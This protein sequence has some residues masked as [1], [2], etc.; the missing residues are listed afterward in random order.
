MIHFL[1]KRHVN[2]NII[3]L[4]IL[5]FFMTIVTGIFNQIKPIELLVFFCFQALC[6]VLPGAAIMALIP[7]K[8]LRRIEKVMLIYASGY[9][10]TILLYA[11]LMLTVGI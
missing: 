10:L 7:V 11:V 2:R 4:L 9:M 8:N 1:K 5:L 3:V 6:I